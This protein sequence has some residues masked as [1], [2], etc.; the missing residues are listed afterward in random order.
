MTTFAIYH[1]SKQNRNTLL[2]PCV[3]VP[4]HVT[5]SRIYSRTLTNQ[6]EKGRTCR[7]GE[8]GEIIK[9]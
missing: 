1:R 7:G 4:I 8:K 9:C 2:S 5:E 6:E 3:F